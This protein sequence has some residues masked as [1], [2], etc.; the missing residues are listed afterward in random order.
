M[1]KKCKACPGKSG[2]KRIF[3]NLIEEYNIQL[4]QGEIKYKK[5]I[6]K[7]SAASLETFSDNSDE[8]ISQLIEDIDDLTLHHFVHGEK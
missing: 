7:G 8:F 5:W 2:V 4:K 6:D 1:T 3:K